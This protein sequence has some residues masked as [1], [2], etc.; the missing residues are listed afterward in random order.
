MQEDI[1]KTKKIRKEKKE[2]KDK[3]KEKK[4]KKEKSIREEKVQKEE[5]KQE[6]Q[7]EENDEIEIVPN[8]NKPR[9]LIQYSEDEE[10]MENN[11][12][13]EYEEMQE[14]E[15][16]DY[17]DIQLRDIQKYNETQQKNSMFK[18]KKQKLMDN[19]LVENKIQFTKKELKSPLHSR[20]RH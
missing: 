10:E 8:P 19:V 2:K 7:I 6:E 4:R 9:V 1:E 12:E 16:D 13:E 3:K 18:G 17:G 15:D 20:L 5:N 11:K 14:E